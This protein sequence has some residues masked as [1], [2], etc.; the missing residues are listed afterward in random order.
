VSGES[1]RDG[2]PEVHA[3]RQTRCEALQEPR[4]AVREPLG[5]PAPGSV[6]SAARGW[7]S[8]S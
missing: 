6:R 8:G 1:Q 5:V 7:R 3:S 4:E 2:D